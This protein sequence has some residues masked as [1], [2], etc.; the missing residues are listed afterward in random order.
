MSSLGDP[1]TPYENGRTL[2]DQL[3]ARLLSVENDGH[4][5]ALQGTNRCTDEI[6]TRYLVELILPDQDPRCAAEPPPTQGGG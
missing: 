5:V 4:T 2:A 1:A 6:V 3:K